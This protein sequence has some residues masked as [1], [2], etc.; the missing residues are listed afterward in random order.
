LHDREDQALGLA[1][2]A[3]DR[4]M[5]IADET[6][7]SVTRLLEEQ[8]ILMAAL[9]A[10]LGAALGA[11]LPLSR[12]EKDML[13]GVGA[14]AVGA[15]RDALASATGVLREEVRKADLGTKVSEKV[16]ELTDK[17]VEGVAGATSKM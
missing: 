1:R 13:G 7:Q 12:Q 11:A 10:A 5:S 17:V 6:R 14:T 15:G 4:A 9:S 8:P 2:Q 16:G 3:Q